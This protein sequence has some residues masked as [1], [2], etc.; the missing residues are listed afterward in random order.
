MKKTRGRYIRRCGDIISAVLKTISQDNAG[1]LWQVLQS[2]PTVNKVLGNDHLSLSQ[3]QNMEA[4]AEAYRNAEKLGYSAPG[5]FCHD[6]F[7][8]L[9]HHIA[10]YPQR[11]R[12]NEQQKSYLNAKFQIGQ[13]TGRKVNADDVARDMR[14]ARN[15]AGV[16]L[17]GVSEFLT[18]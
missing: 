1:N 7:S 13:T 18:A 6:R 12:F 5:P 15:A 3:K 11:D 16:R 4:F 9:C 8:K 17:F 14:K 10:F 2:T